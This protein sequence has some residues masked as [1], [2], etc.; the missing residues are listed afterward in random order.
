MGSN[1]K[2]LVLALRFAGAVMML[3]LFAVV[4]PTE[5][6]AI[7]HRLLGLGEF[8]A[9]PLVEYLTRSVAALYAMHGCL[10]LVLST[11]VVRYRTPLLFVGISNMVFGAVM[12]GI[13][14]YAGLPLHWTLAEGPPVFAFGILLLVLTRR[15]PRQPG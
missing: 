6:M 12:L 5:W 4:M 2:L 7:N 1:A 10:F 13:D 14:L 8:P 9:S 3:A 15:L 11:D